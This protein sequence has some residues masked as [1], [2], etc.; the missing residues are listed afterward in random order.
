MDWKFKKEYLIKLNK[1]NIYKKNIEE[2]NFDQILNKIPIFIECM[3]SSKES[4]LYKLTF[5]SD[6]NKKTI[7]AS[8]VYVLKLFKI[9]SIN[10]NYQK[11]YLINSILEKYLNS[12]IT[13]LYRRL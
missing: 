13:N 10:N 5:A 8:Q 1:K 11:E 2:I 7:L 4:N 9:L 6:L 12:L 3:H